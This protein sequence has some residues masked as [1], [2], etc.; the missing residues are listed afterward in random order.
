MSS[1]HASKDLSGSG[2]Y[3]ATDA[4][5]VSAKELMR[6]PGQSS[7]SF[8]KEEPGENLPPLLITNGQAGLEIDQEKIDRIIFC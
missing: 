6:R 7:C 8:C 5:P 3:R 2:A 4:R 1:S